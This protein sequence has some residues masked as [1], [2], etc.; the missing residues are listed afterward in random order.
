MIVRR[1]PPGR[2]AQ[3]GAVDPADDAGAVP[4]LR[5]DRQSVAAEAL[6]AQRSAIRLAVG[7]Q[8]GIDQWL[9]RATRGHRAFQQ[10]FEFA[11]HLHFREQ[12][13]S[14]RRRARCASVPDQPK[15]CD[16][17]QRAQRAAAQRGEHHRHAK[18]YA[19][20]RKRMHRGHAALDRS[21]RNGQCSARRRDAD[22]G[23]PDGQS[24]READARGGSIDRRK[25]DA[26]RETPGVLRVARWFR[27]SQLAHVASRRDS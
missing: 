9:G 25:C 26:R 7:R 22:H 1:G 21:R 17:H 15:W 5:Q 18:Q 3:R 20:A 27:Q 19:R 16:P 13:R 6:F 8:R 11:A 4:E 23:F 2:P 24:A 12:Q 14:V 10:F